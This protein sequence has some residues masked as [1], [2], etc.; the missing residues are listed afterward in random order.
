[1]TIKLTSEDAFTLLSLLDQEEINNS[2][3]TEALDSHSENSSSII[4]KEERLWLR[5]YEDYSLDSNKKY[6][7]LCEGTEMYIIEADEDEDF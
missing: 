7:V 6:K 5:L 2:T 3:L 4:E 1:M